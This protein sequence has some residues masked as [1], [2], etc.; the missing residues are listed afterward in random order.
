MVLVY[1]TQKYRY[2]DMKEVKYMFLLKFRIR[3]CRHC[4]LGRRS[5]TNPGQGLQ[6][7]SPD[8]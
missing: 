5:L 6:K 8:Y 7:P 3:K 1:K 4:I 2:C